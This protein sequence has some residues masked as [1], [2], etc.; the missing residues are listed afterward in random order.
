MSRKIRVITGPYRVARRYATSMGWHDEEYLIV[1]RGHQ[2]ARLDPAMIA[3]IIE[4]KLNTLGQ[5]IA[6]EIRDE[7]DR[8]RTLWPVPTVA[9]A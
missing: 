1:T 2:L 4:V 8:L 3:T 7:I 9:A 6:D 5:R